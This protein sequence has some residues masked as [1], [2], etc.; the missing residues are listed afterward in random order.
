MNIEEQPGVIPLNN[1]H[2]H[3]TM[4]F[5]EKKKKSTKQNKKTRLLLMLQA[6]TLPDA[7]PPIGN[8]QPFSKIAVAFEPLMGF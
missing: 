8:I 1:P 6:Q 4:T 5:Y 2:K 7:T 3:P